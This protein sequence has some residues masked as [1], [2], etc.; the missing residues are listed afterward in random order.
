[1]V[2]WC[3]GAWCTFAAA[4]QLHDPL[5][6]LLLLATPSPGPC[7]LMRLRRFGTRSIG[8]HRLAYKQTRLAPNFL[9]HPPPPARPPA[10]TSFHRPLA[11]THL[12]VIRNEATRLRTRFYCR[13]IS[14]LP[15]LMGVLLL[16]QTAK[17]HDSE[18][19]GEPEVGSVA[20]AHSCCLI[21]HPD[22]SHAERYCC[23][24][25]KQFRPTARNQDV[26]RPNSARTV[27]HATK[28]P[29][30]I[31]INSGRAMVFPTVTRT[32]GERRGSLTWQK[33][34]RRCCRAEHSGQRR[35]RQRVG[36]ISIS[37]RRSREAIRLY[38]CHPEDFSALSRGHLEDAAGQAVAY[39]A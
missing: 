18:L 20:D 15:P 17:K 32:N 22:S 34:C 9:H 29:S 37:S 10:V 30:K 13:E 16:T 39:G 3:N 23:S 8:H 6:P 14:P 12:V 38:A 33:R 26:L 4:H 31:Q 19:I 21:V 27:L 5:L 24:S 7:E 1:M 2:T 25:L 11:K 36:A 35:Q 28:L